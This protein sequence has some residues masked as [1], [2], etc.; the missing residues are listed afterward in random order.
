MNKKN[1]AL[2]VLLMLIMAFSLGACGNNYKE[3]KTKD[4][5]E[6]HTWILT[7][8]IPNNA[9]VVKHTGEN[10][11]F[12]CTVDNGQFWVHNLQQYSKNATLKPNDTVYWHAWE[13]DS[14]DIIQYA[15]VDIILKVDDNIIGYAVIKILQKKPVTYTASVL[16]SALFPKVRGEYQTITAEQIA[17]II[18]KVKNK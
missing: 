14:N 3:V 16:K 5:I 4:M 12:E 13:N 7:S 15:F 11:V 8:G 9:I 2:G 10:A 6:L 1:T 17:S 18:E